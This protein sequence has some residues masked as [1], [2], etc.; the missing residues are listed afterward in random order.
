MR[1]SDKGMFEKHG[2]LIM[3]CIKGDKTI[4]DISDELDVSYRQAQ[5]YVKL[6]HKNLN[7]LEKTGEKV[8]LNKKEATIKDLKVDKRRKDNKSFPRADLFKFNKEKAVE[9]MLDM[10]ERFNDLP[11]REFNQFLFNLKKLS[12]DQGKKYENEFNIFSNKMK[13]YNNQFGM[14]NILSKQLPHRDRKTQQKYILFRKY[15]KPFLK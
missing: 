13:E 15:V 2:K 14:N 12:E 11:E 3:Q 7:L 10:F 5:D 8:C 6:Y 1:T 9:K 4:Q